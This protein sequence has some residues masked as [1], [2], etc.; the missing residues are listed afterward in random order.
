MFFIVTSLPSDLRVGQ[1]VRYPAISHAIREIDETIAHKYGSA[2]VGVALFINDMV[3]P[4]STRVTALRRLQT[5]LQ[6]RVRNRIGAVPPTAAGR[7]KELRRWQGAG[8]CGHVGWSTK[9]VDLIGI[10]IAKSSS[11]CA[12]LHSELDH[13]P[14]L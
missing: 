2:N 1:L 3:A 4:R 12:G 8:G 7:C 5:F 10:S 13:R 6:H 9:P 14:A 11:L